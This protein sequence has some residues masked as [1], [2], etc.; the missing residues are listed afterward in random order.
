MHLRRPRPLWV[1]GF[2]PSGAPSAET[3]GVPRASHSPKGGAAPFAPF[4]GQ[5]FP[6]P[7]QPGSK[8]QKGLCRRQAFCTLPTKRRRAVTGRPA[9]RIV[10]P[11]VFRITEHPRP[12]RILRDAASFAG[13]AA[14][15]CPAGRPLQRAAA[16]GRLPS[17]PPG[18]V[19]A[20]DRPAVPPLYRSFPSSRR[21]PPARCGRRRPAA[22]RSGGAG[23]AG[24]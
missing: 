21:D 2:S 22:G 5:D 19:K 13:S 23:R 24:R 4:I 18:A 16:A 17:P 11:C 1:P 9:F 20:P 3:P 6:F 14:L 10:F 12:G 15:L 7:V 8:R